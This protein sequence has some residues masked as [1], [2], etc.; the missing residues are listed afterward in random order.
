MKYLSLILKNLFRNRRRTVLTVFSI[1]VSMFIFS[2]LASVP[3]AV[4]QVLS[5]VASSR[6]LVVHNRAGLAYGLPPAYL[7]KILAL[8]HVEAAVAQSRY[9][10]IYHEVTD[11]FPNWDARHRRRVDKVFSD[12]G[13][14]DPDLARV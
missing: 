4:N 13:V 6:R 14:A 3:M 10:G 1:A 8:P 12:W 9:G 11:Q 2:T 7:P 5:N